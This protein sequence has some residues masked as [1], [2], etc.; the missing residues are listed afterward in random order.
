MRI[1]SVLFVPLL[2]TAIVAHPGHRID[3]EL[4]KRAEFLAQHTN[5][6]EHCASIHKA[7]GLDKRAIDR[8]AAR[9]DELLKVRGL[10]KRQ[11]SPLDKSHKSDKPYTAKT[12]PSEVFSGA[13]SCVLSPEATEGPFYVTG[14]SIR[15]NLVDGELGVP[16][17]LDI[18]LIDVNTCKPVKDVYLEIWGANSTGVYSGA[19]ALVNGNGMNDKSNLNKAF[20]RGIQQTDSD[21]VVQFDTNFPGHYAGRATHMHVI[22][23]VEDTK[24]KE[25]STIWDTRVRHAG[26]VFF[27]QALINSIETNAPYSTNRQSRTAN[28]NDAILI[29]ETANKADPFFEYVQLGTNLKDGVFGWFSLGVN[30][31]YSRSIMAVAQKFKEGG[32]MV[33]TNPKI[34][35]FDAIFPGGFPTAFQPG[36]KAAAVETDVPKVA[37]VQERD[38]SK[39]APAPQV[40]GEVE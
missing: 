29:Q 13:K 9:V 4:Q 10:P 8:R 36:F 30:M 7:A 19:L 12:S 33:T 26:Q 6:L 16:L 38:G 25:N 39:E 24:A 35:G 15:T 20:L 27:D 34:A 28:K 14:E 5:N 40:L 3:K 18:Q 11:T 22:T 1:P 2:A 21:G 23:H 31:T 37:N 17:H 32:K